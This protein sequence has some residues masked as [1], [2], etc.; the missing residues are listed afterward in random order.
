LNGHAIRAGT[1]VIVA[2]WVLHRHKT[3]WER[4]DYFEPQRFMPAQREQIDRFA[5]L[6]FGAGPRICIGMGF[7]MQEA[8]I[9]LASILRHYRLDIAPGH[10][11]EPVMRITLRPKGGM[12]MLLRKR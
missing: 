7:A 6:P 12:P 4:P 3:L 10:K 11:V 2:P 8:M 1:L 9:L 5:Y